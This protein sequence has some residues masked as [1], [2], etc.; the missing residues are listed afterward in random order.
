MYQVRNV[1]AEKLCRF[2]ASGEPNDDDLLW[3]ET[4]ALVGEPRDR[5]G[6]VLERNRLEVRGESGKAEVRE[7]KGCESVLGQAASKGH[8]SGRPTA[9]GAT[10][11]HHRG[12]RITLGGEVRTDELTQHRAIISHESW[13]GENELSALRLDEATV[14]DV[15]RTGHV[16]RSLGSLERH[17]GGELFRGGEAPRCETADAGD[18]CGVDV[19]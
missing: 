1:D 13:V 4:A 9:F 2:A 19:D 16:R 14:D 6:E 7:R 5:V 12:C 10:E 3:S 17:Q 8:G 18:R 11:Q 15:V